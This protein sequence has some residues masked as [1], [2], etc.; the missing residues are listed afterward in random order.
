MNGERDE[1][2]SKGEGHEQVDQMQLLYYVKRPNQEEHSYLMDTGYD[3]GGV[4]KNSKWNKYYLHNVLSYNNSSTEGAYN[5]PFVSASKLRKVSTHPDVNYLYNEDASN[6]IDVI[7]A[8]FPI[9]HNDY[10]GLH[11][12]YSSLYRRDLLLIKGDPTSGTKTYL[13][14]SNQ[15]KYTS[16]LTQADAWNAGIS[17]NYYSDSESTEFSGSYRP[18]SNYY[19]KINGVNPFWV[20]IDMVEAPLHGSDF[21]YE[22][23]VMV[24]EMNGR[25]ISSKNGYPASRIGIFKNTAKH[26]TSTSWSSISFL[27]AMNGDTRPSK[28]TQQI[29]YSQSHTTRHYQA[30][31]QEHSA[32][33]V[34]IVI[35]RTKSTD[36][37][38]IILSNYDDFRVILKEN[39][40][41]GFVRL[42]RQ[43]NQ[44]VYD[45][46]YLY[47]VYPTTTFVGNQTITENITF[48]ND[49]V[50]DGEEDR[51]TIDGATVIFEP[52]TVVKFRGEQM[53][54]SVINGGKI[55][56]DGVTFI[57]EGNGTKGIGISSDNSSFK[58]CT[59]DGFSYALNLNNR[60]T[61]IQNCTFKNNQYGILA[62]H[63]TS[64]HLKKCTFEDNY[65]G[66]YT[67]GDLFLDGVDYMNYS[68]NVFEDNTYG[69]ATFNGDVS[70]N[71][72]AFNSNTTA[73]YPRFSSNLYFGT[74]EIANKFYSN[75][76]VVK[77]GTYSSI[78]ATLQYYQG[79]T[80]AYSEQVYYSPA[81]SLDPTNYSNTQLLC[82]MGGSRLKSAV[83]DGN[84]YSKMAVNATSSDSNHVDA[85]KLINISLQALASANLK[86]LSNKELS[87]TLMILLRYK[88][89][90]SEDQF[91]QFKTFLNK[92]WNSPDKLVT[93]DFRSSAAQIYIKMLLLEE[94]YDEA[95]KLIFRFQKDARFKHQTANYVS[96]EFNVYMLTN[97]WSNALEAIERL[98]ALELNSSATEQLTISKKLQSKFEEIIGKN[99]HDEL[100]N[101]VNEL[102]SQSEDLSIMILESSDRE[103]TSD[104]IETSVDIY[105]N[106]FNPITTVRF[107]LQTDQNVSIEVYNIMGQL[108]QELTN[109]TYT[110]GTHTI[111]FNGSNLST[112]IYFIKSRI[113]VQTFTQ[114]ITLSK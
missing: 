6:G 60:F 96:L 46:E 107:T 94:S 48:Y 58:N 76:K 43:N 1:S 31:A 78:Y 105:P 71:N 73:L 33:V 83:C 10:I 23:G 95:L 101:H 67:Y 16:Y 61:T 49:V 108:I 30:W 25:D 80:P 51:L 110:A 57:D 100:K 20:Y 45:P 62:Y 17:L 92:A 47:N 39:K 102:A 26:L 81:I 86:D 15:D 70:L 50:I 87:N 24:R 91:E 69:I 65:Y 42:I 44:W 68:A 22:N 75:N 29:Q 113:G 13:I 5:G 106:P 55:I 32:N 21:N 4:G 74:Y 104:P 36:A 97:Q 54:I 2:I 8:E 72:A 99:V 18:S 79:S 9:E 63:N 82:D 66:V 84:L 109:S 35:S 85:I 56:A 38:D 90:V 103:L 52:G 114:K 11:N 3:A 112:G 77:N 14:D 89:K 40:D 28:P 19:S 37:K 64:I 34:D 93:N 88:D 98:E 12:I 111:S 27:N 59:F 7:R 53:I 41:I